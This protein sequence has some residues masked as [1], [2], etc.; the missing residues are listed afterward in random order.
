MADVTGSI[1]VSSTGYAHEETSR[2]G[3]FSCFFW[4]G[5]RGLLAISCCWDWLFP[6][7]GLGFGGLFS[8]W[9]GR[10]NVRYVKHVG[11]HKKRNSSRMGPVLSQ[12]AFSE[13]WNASHIHRHKPWAP[14][15]R[16]PPGHVE[17][18]STCCQLEAEAVGMIDK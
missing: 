2:F 5:I 4:W 18:N 7:G 17:R 8:V 13:S 12:R 1:P 14:V 6:L 16:C 9:A 10:V 11:C 15:P 3:W